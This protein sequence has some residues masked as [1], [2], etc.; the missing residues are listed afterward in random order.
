MGVCC[1]R[2]PAIQT[3]GD[4]FLERNRVPRKATT[5]LVRAESGVDQA[6]KLLRILVYFAVAIVAACVA[7]AFSL[8]A[9]MG[10]KN[11]GSRG[12][13][14]FL[15]LGL[16]TGWATSFLLILIL[17]LVARKLGPARLWLW[18]LLGACW[19]PLGGC[20]EGP[21]PSTLYFGDQKPYSKF[22]G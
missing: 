13:A 15:Y 14:L 22:G 17:T 11:G 21:D 7:T 8:A 12:F 20:M 5:P 4:H 2:R 16:M 10:Q 18:L 19:H 1:A 9:F 3:C 6:G